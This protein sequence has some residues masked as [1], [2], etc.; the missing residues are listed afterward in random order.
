MSDL[1]AVDVKL[2]L[3]FLFMFKNKL[4]LRN[5]IAIVI[6]LAATAMFSACS[7]DDVTDEKAQVA[8]NACN[9]SDI[10]QTTA[11]VS[12]NVTKAGVPAYTERGI[13]W[14]THSNPTISDNKQTATGSGQVG[15]YSCSITG[16]TANTTY[17]AKA[18]VIQNGTA[19][20]ANEITFKTKQA[21]ETEN[22]QVTTN[23]CNE[24]DIT[25]TTAVVYAN[26]SKAGVPSYTERGICW[27]TH[28]NPTVND[29]KKT[30][31]GSGQAGSYSCTITGL[32]ANTTYYAKAYVI[33]NGTAI[34]ANEINFKTKPTSETEEAQIRALLAKLY[35]DTKGAGWKTKTNWLSDKP[36]SEWYG[37]TYSSENLEIDLYYNN[38]IG[39]IDLSGCTVLTDLDCDNN[40][41]ISLNV[42]GCTALEELYCSENQLTSLNVSGCTALIKLVCHSTPLISLNVNGCTALTKL[43]CNRNQLTSLN[44]SG[45]TA[46]E[47]LWCENNRLTSVN[48][49]G[50][51]ALTHFYGESNQLNSL[52]V[53][54]CTKLT[55]LWCNN[56]LLTATALNTVFGMLP[57]SYD[58]YI[59]VANNPG[60]STCT[61]SIAEAKGWRVDR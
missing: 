36:I 28:S 47:E 30:A 22:A 58:G 11:T 38:L 12:A 46:L 56:S 33:Q 49:S 17:Y 39:T 41:L 59:V 48:M 27:G 16:L 60:S 24:S 26:V 3:K 54:G 4:N 57:Y 6:C 29:N 18:Y 10:T 19:I 52:D 61:P 40:Q 8:T 23:A 44:V 37:I 25:E 7:K 55:T 32:T 35:N 53:S 2:K 5:V 51:T 50:C 13:Y 1:G 9:D 15:S 14:S 31:T 21:G 34:Y 20:Y 42:S 45:C 43:Y